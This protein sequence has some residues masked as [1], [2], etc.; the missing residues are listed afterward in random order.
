M[1]DQNKK[2]LNVSRTNIYSRNLFKIHEKEK[3]ST[4]FCYYFVLSEENQ[5]TGPQLKDE[6]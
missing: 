3:S 1:A 2:K 5:L 6:I 4:F